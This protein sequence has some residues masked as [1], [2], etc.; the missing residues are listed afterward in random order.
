MPIN[1]ISTHILLIY[2]PQDFRT[3][4]IVQEEEPKALGK[5]ELVEN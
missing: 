2:E 5:D 4:N 1:M 3:I